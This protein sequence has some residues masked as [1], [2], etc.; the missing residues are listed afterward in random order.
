MKQVTLN[1]SSRDAIGRVASRRLRAEGN[2]PA[3]IYG[4][5]GVRHLSVARSDFRRL[6]KEIAGRTALVEL[7]DGENKMLSIIQDTQ[8]DPRSDSFEHIDFKEIQRGKEMIADVAIRVVGAS[9]GVRNEGAIQETQIH[10]V[11]VR[12]RPRHLPEVIEVDV[13]E[14][15][16]GDV[17]HVRDLPALEGVTYLD[18]PD[19]PVV[20]IAGKDTSATA[21]DEEGEEGAED[22][23]EIQAED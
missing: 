20:A 15:R 12:C 5:S 23:A 18:D 17:V 1:V 7:I 22:G 9:Y 2:I 10:E 13:T 16:L 11:R 19:I 6:W 8:R 3:V 4:E 21:L 14:L